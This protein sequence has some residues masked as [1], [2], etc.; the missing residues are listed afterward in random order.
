METKS[1]QVSWIVLTVALVPAMVS[2]VLLAVA[3]TVFIAGEF[4]SFTGG[5]LSE[6][7]EAQPAAY[8]FLLL[9]DSELGVFLFGLLLLTL[10]ITVIPYRKGERWAWY[11]VLASLILSAIGS[12]GLNIPTGDLGVVIL[13]GFIHLVALVGLAIG[14]RPHFR[15]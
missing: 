15:K 11:A 3:P 7:A 5:S 10:L 12:V 14:V 8:A 1:L 2:G 9:E 13:T 4:A 6:F